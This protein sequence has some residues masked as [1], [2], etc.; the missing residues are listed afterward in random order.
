MTMAVLGTLKGA[1]RWSE[2]SC[3]SG[4][5]AQVTGSFRSLLVVLYAVSVPS[6]RCSDLRKS[7]PDL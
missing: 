6:G 1:G 3:P 7:F 2:E 5:R 4:I